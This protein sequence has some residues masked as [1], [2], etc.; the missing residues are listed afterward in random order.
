MLLKLLSR[1]LVVLS[2]WTFTSASHADDKT[3][4]QEI[5]AQLDSFHAQFGQIV[6]DAQGQLLQEANGEL[7]L[8]QPDKLYWEVLEPNE[9]ILV[10]DGSTVWHID[11]FVEQVVAIDQQQAIANNP[12][13]LITSSDPAVWDSFVIEQT[14]A[15][16]FSVSSTEDDAFIRSLQLVFDNLTLTKLVFVDS[17]GQR[18]ELAFSDIRQNQSVDQALFEFRLPE[19]YD[20][21]DQRGQ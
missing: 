18:S 6:T 5:L 2:I 12:L 1:T 10:A 19:G 11:P 4:L 13:M 17:Q 7:F 15:G 20:L 3:K 21:D 9:N 8:M 16:Q 14:N